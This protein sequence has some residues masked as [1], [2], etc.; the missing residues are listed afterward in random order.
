[1]PETDG[2]MGSNADLDDFIREQREKCKNGNYP[3][4]K[5]GVC[6]CGNG[7]EEKE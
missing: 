4:C 6:D 2:S 5:K 1:M 3:C 7:N